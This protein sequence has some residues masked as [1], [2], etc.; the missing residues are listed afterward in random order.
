MEAVTERTTIVYGDDI[1][2]MIGSAML[3]RT[4]PQ[5]NQQQQQQ[6]QQQQ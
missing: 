2:D 5:N 6:Q 4:V 3:D 1:P